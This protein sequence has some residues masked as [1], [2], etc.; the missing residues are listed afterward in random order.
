MANVG[1]SL[2]LGI[3]K[4]KI[5]QSRLVVLAHFL[6]TVVPITHV[7]VWVVKS[8]LPA[9]FVSARIVHPNVKPVVS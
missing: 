2:N 4:Y 6:K 5:K 3:A 9:K 1:D 7:D 8:M